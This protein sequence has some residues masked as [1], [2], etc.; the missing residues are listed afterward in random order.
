M[1]APP[2]PKEIDW[3]NP[4]QSIAQLVEQ[5]VNQR[6]QGFTQA[7]QTAQIAEAQ[8][9]A[10]SSWDD[11]EKTLKANPKLFEGIEDDVRKA[12]FTT[13]DPIVQR[14]GDVTECYKNPKN[15][16]AAAL[17][18]RFKRGEIDA[19]RIYGTPA[20]PTPMKPGATELPGGSRPNATEDIITLDERTREMMREQGISEGEAREYIKLGRATRR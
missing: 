13:Y 9:K 3:S 6:F 19:S 1:D 11:G 7:L 15:W 2:K 16:E 8:N 14:G 17:L 12:M 20:P 5:G 10:F 18:V 4:E